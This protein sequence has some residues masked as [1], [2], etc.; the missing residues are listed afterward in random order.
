MNF[1]SILFFK[2]VVEGTLFLNCTVST[3]KTIHFDLVPFY[4]RMTKNTLFLLKKLTVS[5][6]IPLRCFDVVEQR[7]L[8]GALFRTFQRNRNQ[9]K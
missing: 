6:F 1:H 9:H 7:I 4:K 8:K 2:I 3:K 5:H